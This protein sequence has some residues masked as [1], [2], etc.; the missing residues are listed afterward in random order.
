MK[1]MLGLALMAGL[2][3]PLAGCGW[4]TNVPAQIR[5][6]SIDP[7]TVTYKEPSAGAKATYDATV[8]NAV[9]T[10]TGE[11][12]SI[13]ASFKNAKIRYFVPGGKDPVIEKSYPIDLRI[14]SSGFREDPRKDELDD[15]NWS[16]R[17]LIIGTGQLALPML[18][19]RAVLDYGF[20]KSSSSLYA[21]IEFTGEDDAKYPQFLEV[22]VPIVFQGFGQ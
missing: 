14:E 22:S 9:L 4:Y 3:A 7:I 11:P 18:I 16:E 12:G 21:L 1:R 2:M 20:Q 8:N 6:K 15:G 17:K 13:G 19:D 5:V 10:L